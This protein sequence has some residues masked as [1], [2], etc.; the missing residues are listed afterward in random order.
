MRL[1]LL[2]DNPITGLFPPIFK[3]KRGNTSRTYPRNNSGSLP[4]SHRS[5]IS[6][7]KRE[8]DRGNRCLPAGVSCRFFCEGTTPWYRPRIRVLVT[9]DSTTAPVPIR[10]L[11]TRECCRTDD[12]TSYPVRGCVKKDPV[13]P[14]PSGFSGKGE[15]HCPLCVCKDEPVAGNGE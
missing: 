1:K 10:T 8:R 14:F 7:G 15:E 2:S 11:R 3:K 6:V 9:S 13:P 12:H 5:L 4:G